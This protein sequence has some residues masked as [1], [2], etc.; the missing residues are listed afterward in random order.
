VFANGLLSRQ[1]DA[2]LR[3]AR[4]KLAAE[5]CAGRPPDN[6]RSRVMA[7]SDLLNEHMGAVTHVEANGGYTIRGEGCPLSALT[8]K[9][10]SV[11]R[12]MESLVKES[13]GASVHECC[14]RVQRPRCCFEIK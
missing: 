3:E 4:K 10:P 1:V 2:L 11:C 6:L 12:A 5:L 7:A 9:H 13:V 14:E 8:A